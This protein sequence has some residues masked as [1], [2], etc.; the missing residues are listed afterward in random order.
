MSRKE[1]IIQN[2]LLQEIRLDKIYLSHIL[3][4]RKMQG[5]E[6]DIYA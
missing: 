3:Q 2:A 1:V 4:Q 5:K 6:S